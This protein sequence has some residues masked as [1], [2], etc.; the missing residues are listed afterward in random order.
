MTV[1]VILSNKKNDKQDKCKV[2]ETVDKIMY[3]QRC[4][5]KNTRMEWKGLHSTLLEIPLQP[6]GSV[7]LLCWLLCT[8]IVIT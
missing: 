4:I 8:D 5:Y 1:E 6:E 7:Y 2:L 3:M